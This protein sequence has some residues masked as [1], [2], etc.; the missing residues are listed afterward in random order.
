M[1]RLFEMELHEE[2]Y[3][4]NNANLLILRVPGGWV[5]ERYSENGTGGYDMCSTFVPLSYDLK[6]LQGDTK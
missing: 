6:P 1:D 2:L 3:P 4:K 5:Y